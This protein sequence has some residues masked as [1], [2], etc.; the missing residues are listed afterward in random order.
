MVAQLE[1]FEAGEPL[2]FELTHGDL[3]FAVKLDETAEHGVG[4]DENIVAFS[5]LCPHMGC[6]IDPSAA[7]PST[8]HFGPCGCH[9]SLFNL[10]KDGRM[11]RGRAC[12]NLARIELE[13]RGNTVVALGKARPAFGDP[14]QE[15]HALTTVAAVEQAE[16]EVQS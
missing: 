6:P 9:Q 4:P 15:E 3:C 12:S 13:V 10:R 1:E 5:T 2:V 7:D 11:V 14:L 16:S 8:G